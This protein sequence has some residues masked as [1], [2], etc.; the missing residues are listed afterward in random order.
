MSCLVGE[1]R[2]Q[3]GLTMFLQIQLLALHPRNEVM[4]SIFVLQQVEAQPEGWQ[5]GQRQRSWSSDARKTLAWSGSE[6]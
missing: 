4:N 2:G 1:V 6:L 5:G 3:G